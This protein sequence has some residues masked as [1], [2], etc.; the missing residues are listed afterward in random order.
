VLPKLA[1]L[2]LC[3]TIQLLALL[4][5]GDAAK[6]LEILVLRHQ[7]AV[8]RRQVARPRFEPADRALLA[9]LSRVLPRPAGP[10]SSSSPRRCCAG[11]AGWS[12]RLDLPAS[13]HEHDVAGIPAPAGR[14]DP[15]RV[16]GLATDRGMPTPGAGIARLH[17]ALQ[18]SSA[19]SSAPARIAGS[20]RRLGRSLRLAK[21]GYTDT[22]CSAVSCLSTSELHE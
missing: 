4:V 10:A 5:R 21:A 12:R 20:T 18:R 13:A 1:Y 15:R 2:S 22:I 6:D 16:P 9:A 11:T 17:R 19:A 3:R 7:L 8:L 14:R